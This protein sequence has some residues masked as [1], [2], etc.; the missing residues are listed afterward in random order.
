MKIKKIFA[1]TLCTATITISGC[2]SA[3]VGGI[4]ALA[5]LVAGLAGGGGGDNKKALIAVSPSSLQFSDQITAKPSAPQTIQI[6]NNGEASLSVTGVSVT[7]VDASVFT[8]TNECTSPVTPGQSCSVKVIFAPQSIGSKSA[9]VA[10]ASNASNTAS[11]VAVSGA[12]VLPPAPS[13]AAVSTLNVD[14]LG[15]VETR[16]SGKVDATDPNGLPLTYSV[17]KQSLRGTVTFA[18]AQSDAGKFEYVIPG[19][20]DDGVPDTDSFEI[21]VSNGYTSTL[22][23]LQVTLATDPLLKNQWHLKNTGQDAFASELPVVGNDMRVSAAWSKGYSGK[24][25][26]VAVVDDGLEAEHEDL[27]S[28]VDV[29]ASFNFI[30]REN[31]P[32]PP[33][34]DEPNTDSHGTSVGGIIAATAFNALGGRGVA[35]GATLRGYNWLGTGNERTI[36]DLVSSFGGASFSK[37]NDIFNASF[38]RNG[39]SVIVINGVEVLNFFLPSYDEVT[40]DIF[41]NSR[42]LRSEKGALVIK[43]AG[44]NFGGAYNKTYDFSQKCVTAINFGSTCGHPSADS[45]NTNPNVLVVAASNAKGKRASYSSAGS[46]IWV[47]APGGEYGLRKAFQPGRK[48]PWFYEPAIVTTARTGCEYRDES[49]KLNDLDSLG[50]HPE[51]EDCQYT[52]TMN[53][54]SSAAPNTS[55]VI[56]LMLEANGKLTAR[57]IKHIL[58]QTAFRI[59]PGF[60][61]ISSNQI[62]PGQAFAL[63]LGWVQ[64]KAGF[65]FSNWYGFGLVDAGAAVSAAASY[66][67]FLPVQKTA[68][69]SILKLT[70]DATI[71][72]KKSYSIN[73]TISGSLSVVES[74]SLVANFHT[75]AVFCNQI[76]LTSPSGTNSILLPAFTGFSNVT[77][78]NARF[79]SHAF[80]GESANGVWKAT[81][82]NVC[83]V[84]DGPTVINADDEQTLRV[85]GR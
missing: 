69:D 38:G 6:S 23:T 79:T 60:S 76:S 14:V 18:Q 43:S 71:D 80:Y 67:N 62:I 59:D 52:A 82:H 16:K 77:L 73:F 50:N 42:K 20:L 45:G 58:A 15:I 33:S 66:T 48:D 28:N 36:D 35:Y 17:S 57:D 29:A 3:S 30:T 64:N 56:A 51:A 8:V 53:G 25:V 34:E 31:D 78:A 11:P 32:T 70:K 5:A 41:N 7:G 1:V 49:E 39:F 65:W 84:N 72:P 61:G 2:G 55:G 40:D 27:E 75:P 44:N 9:S 63:D 47:T 68:P 74:V 81:Y 13:V 24:G 83:D 21:K 26:R 4:G 85:V 37:D 10:I 12:G 46:S 54:T 22:K 19:H